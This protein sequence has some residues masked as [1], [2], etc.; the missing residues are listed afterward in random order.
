[1]IGGGGLAD[2][3]GGVVEAAGPLYEADAREV[4]GEDVVGLGVVVAGVVGAAEKDTEV[5]G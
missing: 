1:M 4:G 5:D 2:R 3:G